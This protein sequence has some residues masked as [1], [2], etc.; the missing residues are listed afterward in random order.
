M[1]E[2]NFRKK[3]GW[4]QFVCCILVIW[5]HAGNA[6]LFLGE[7]AAGH[8]LTA[9]QNGAA[10][11]IARASIPCFLMLSA[12][13]FYRNFSWK[14]LVGKW[15]RRV[16]SLLV[17]YLVWNLLYYFGYLLASY[18]PYL[19][20]IINRRQMA[21][22]LTGMIRAALLYEANP[23][24]W[25]MFQLLLLTVLAPVLYLAMEHAA[26]GILWLGLLLWGIAAGV[27]LPWLNLDALTY[28]SVAA[29]AAL[30]ARQFVECRW[31]R[32][33][34]ILGAELVILGAVCAA[35]YYLHA[36]IPA[37]VLSRLLVPPGMWLLVNERWLAERRPFME[38]TFFI[39]AFH[40]LPV[41]LINKL[42][43]MAFP[44]HVV[45]AAGLFLVMPAVA[46]A[47]CWQVAKLLM[48][49]AAPAWYVLTGGRGASSGASRGA[50]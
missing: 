3:V 10:L 48:R 39:Y 11:E 4:F 41:R 34:G 17:P 27:Q 32:Y 35:D 6:E 45:L 7:S 16:T 36:R 46:C 1:E 21:F 20:D 9:F 24:F 18:L 13:L 22:S 8:P 30:H 15:K 49:F 5:N 37:I 28:Y 31:D 38:C 2:R 47:I 43:A 40:F 42:A 23:V 12:Y 44:G 25:F 33:R 50:S 14:D 26:I 29:F 19:S